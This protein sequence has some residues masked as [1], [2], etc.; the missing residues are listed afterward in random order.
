MFPEHR[1][2]GAHRGSGWVSSLDGGAAGGWLRMGVPFRLNLLLTTESA[3]TTQEASHTGCRH[4][5]SPC[6]CL[7]PS[8]SHL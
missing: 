4:E 8:I 3:W 6:G 7:P 5:R 1:M 2:S